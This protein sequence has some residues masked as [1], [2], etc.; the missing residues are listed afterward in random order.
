VPLSRLLYVSRCALESEG[1]EL[2]AQVREIAAA[3]A[4]RNRDAEVTGS[5]L[6]V[7][8]T[9]I[10]VLEGPTPAVERTFEV[11]CCDF[12]HDD[13][14]LIDLVPIKSRAFPDWSMAYLSG[15]TE[16]RVPLADDMEEIRFLVGINAREAV[17]QMRRLLDK[18]NH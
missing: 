3:S 17:N 6:H 8:D 16:T 18:T 9:F 4:L 10:Q 13:V 2:S 12:R 7:G 15:D 11:I 14:K 5:L 1:V